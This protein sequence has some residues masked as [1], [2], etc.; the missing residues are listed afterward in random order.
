MKKK[1]MT[2]VEIKRTHKKRRYQEEEYED[3]CNGNN[4]ETSDN[5]IDKINKKK[6]N[7]KKGTS[8]YLK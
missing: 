2:T 3:Y 8:N 7:L 6:H 1:M 5:D 4:D